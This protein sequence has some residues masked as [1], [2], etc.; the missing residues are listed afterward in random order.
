MAKYSNTI[1][2][3]AESPSNVGC[4]KDADAEAATGT[5]GRPPFMSMSFRI[6]IAE[7]RSGSWW[8]L[9]IFIHRNSIACPATGLIYT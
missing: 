4:L 3:H 7:A 9:C 8:R 5:V 1:M 2:E 6:P